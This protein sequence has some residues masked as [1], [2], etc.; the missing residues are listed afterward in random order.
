MCI[1]LL[2]AGR[3]ALSHVPGPTGF[4]YHCAADMQYCPQ[5]LILQ[6]SLHWSPVELFLSPGFERKRSLSQRLKFVL[7]QDKVV[8]ID[9]MMT[10]D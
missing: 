4:I 6:S 5:I 7:R 1:R 10:H 3:K 8:L 9:R 2:H